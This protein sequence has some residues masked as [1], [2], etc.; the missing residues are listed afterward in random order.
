MR[1]FTSR[2][3]SWLRPAAVA[4]LSLSL[5]LGGVGCTRKF[6]RQRADK[7]VAA[8]L[9]DKDKVE[10][11]KIEHAGVYPPEAARFAD[12]TNPDR[13]PMPPDDPAAYDLSPNPQKPGK[14]GVAY[15]EGD[16]Y[17]K[18]V[19]AWDAEN[20]AHDD[21]ENKDSPL[22]VWTGQ[23]LP[24]P[25]GIEEAARFG[26]D[27]E[28][29][30]AYK[31]KLEQAVE[32][33][34]INSREYQAR[35]EDL[36]LA[37]LPVTLERF[38]F[39]AQWFAT[40]DIFREYTGTKTG[41]GKANRW[42]GNGS[43]GVTKLFSTGALLLARFANTTIYE[44]TDLEQPLKSTSTV[45][46]EAM[47]PVL[48]G[49]GRAVT[50]EPLTQV[51]RNLLY[52]IR[53]YARFRKEF[54]VNI[55]SGGNTSFNVPNTFSG[56]GGVTVAATG[57]VG[58]GGDTASATSGTGTGGAAGA[59]T[60][61]T[62]NPA[63]GAGGTGFQ[64][65]T[66]GRGR[67]VTFA[68]G[69]GAPSEG[70]LT[71]LQRKAILRNE[72]SNV[73]AFLKLLELFRN[74]EEGGRISN[75]QTGQVEQA[76]QQA[77]LTVLQRQQEYRDGL[78]RFKLQLGLPTTFCLEPDECI[79]L[80]VAEQIR[81]YDRLIQQARKVYDD[82]NA[83]STTPPNQLR[84]KLRLL[85][86]ESDLVQD[87]P[88]QKELPEQWARW[89][90]MT[91]K[92]IADELTRLRKQRQDL[93]DRRDQLQL[94]NRNLSEEE[95]RRLSQIEFEIALGEFEFTPGTTD[96]PETGLR[97]YEKEPWKV[98][99]NPE[100]R[101]Q[102][103][104]RR[105]QEVFNQFNAVI[106]EARNQR[107]ARLRE[108][109]PDLP[110]VCLCGE[111]LLEGELDEDLSIAA[112]ETLINRFDLMNARAQLVDSWRKV[113][114][115]ANALMGVFDVKYHL[116]S[117]TPPD[118]AQPI[119]FSG[120]RSRHQLIFNTELPLVR[121]QE[122]NAYRAALI[123]FQRQRRAVM[124]YEDQALLDVRSEIR[125]L[126]VLARNYK[127][128]QRLLE[129]AYLQ[130]ENSLDVFTQPPAP[131]QAA[132]TAA[133]QAALTNQL[134]GAYRSL[135]QTQNQL[136]TLWV[137]YLNTRLQLYRDLEL[138]PLDFRGVWTDDVAKQCARPDSGSESERQ[139]GSEPDRPETLPAPRRFP[140]DE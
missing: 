16:G 131:G 70:F 125:Q 33:G 134:L 45:L 110:G 129:I 55:A 27:S 34:L 61:T 54:F 101:T 8:I 6:F 25:P 39:A 91:E 126:R 1:L 22:L 7:E 94:E 21:G 63:G 13:P 42:R 35:R 47:Q 19:A 132:D 107:L 127:I 58:G 32:L 119:A 23:P 46:L 76:L 79:L 62:P 48:R 15:L 56:S 78:D 84:G 14:S 41:D 20:R 95:V 83:L 121:K 60:V 57:G 64:T 106:T 4:G 90:K 96:R 40:E 113:A 53:D 67:L 5:L 10:R 97:A 123:A 72:R 50:L 66:P 116:D 105:F 51:E 81:R 103:Q 124:S 86:T 138:M 114:V 133:A 109:W 93:L 85:F 82:A 137:N 99:V 87:V 74:Y 115:G 68:P 139:P 88:F 59:G 92:E 24:D 112:R 140:A 135:P 111:D 65:V 73:V 122:R 29:Q 49:G 43:L 36:Y 120:S 17:L 38:A 108:S 18:L 117:S 11:W 98:E 118:E 77:R 136:F 80:P 2:L 31:L 89:E 69:V 71:L 44:F 75:L 28:Q 37:T 130:V 3:K 30:Q 128:Q 100:R 26:D 9:A 104:S 52:E 12:P 102:I